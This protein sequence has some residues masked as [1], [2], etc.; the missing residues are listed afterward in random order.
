MDTRT[1]Y[2]GN[3]RSDHGAVHLEDGLRVIFFDLPVGGHDWRL[4][5]F[6]CAT[7]VISL[8]D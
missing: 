8:K 6:F 7:A 2:A 4:S 1:G 3:I 5:S